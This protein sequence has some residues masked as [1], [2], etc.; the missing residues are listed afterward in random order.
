MG[1]LKPVI[2]WVGCKERVMSYILDRVPKSY[3]TYWEPFVGGG[4]GSFS[5]TA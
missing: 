2:R 3:R 5:T 1:E 4:I